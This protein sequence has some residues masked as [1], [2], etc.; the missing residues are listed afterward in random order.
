MQLVWVDAGTLGAGWVSSSASEWSWACLG[1]LSYIISELF[2]PFSFLCDYLHKRVFVTTFFFF[3]ERF[4]N[5]FLIERGF[6][7]VALF[8]RQIFVFF[9]RR[10]MYLLN[11]HLGFCSDWLLNLSPYTYSLF[12]L[13]FNGTGCLGILGRGEREEKRNN[14]DHFNC[15]N[16]LIL[17]NDGW[18][19]K[20]C[21]SSSIKMQ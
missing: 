8:L 18:C 2:F 17:E 1:F 19:F 7:L 15:G 9:P 4:I 12:I 21:N 20:I 5:I 6:S 3:L 11:Y 14:R 10:V 16:A 13:H